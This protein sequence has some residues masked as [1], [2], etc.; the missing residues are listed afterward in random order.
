MIALIPAGVSKLLLILH[1]VG[2]G[3]LFGSS[4]HSALQSI[5]QLRGRANPRLLRLYPSVALGAWSVTFCLGAALYPRYRVF[6]RNDVFDRHDVWASILFDCKENA[7]LLAGI[8]FFSAFLQRKVIPIS[9][10]QR[11]I[12]LALTLAAASLIWFV[13]ISGLLITSVK[14]V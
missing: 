11:R 9:T 5:A 13:S 2:A 6:V 14:G 7:A 12:H 8:L 3:V 4:T 1:A 10:V